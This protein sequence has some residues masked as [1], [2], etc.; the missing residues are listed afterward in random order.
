MNASLTQARRDVPDRHPSV[1]VGE[2]E[3]DPAEVLSALGDPD[4]RQLLSA[5]EERPRTAQEC[6]D[7]CDL[8]LSTV[9]RKLELL[10]DAG[11]LEEGRR[12]R[13]RNNHPTEFSTTFDTLAVSLRAGDELSVDFRQVAADG[14][15]RESDPESR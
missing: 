6:A 14:D 12:I 5:C 10:G 1:S 9:Y 8:P 2:P 13:S 4:C 3:A 7:A 15:G 11:L